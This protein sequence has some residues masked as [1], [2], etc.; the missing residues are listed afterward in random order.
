MLFDI[1]EVLREIDTLSSNDN[2]NL[3]SIKELLNRL[4]SNLTTHDEVFSYLD[5][6]KEQ[7]E[8]EDLSDSFGGWGRDKDG[9]AVCFGKI[10]RKL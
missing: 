10:I 1:S 6:L 2:C 3:V 4:D 7:G 9:A 8:I 5:A